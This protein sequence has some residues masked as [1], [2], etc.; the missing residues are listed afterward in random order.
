[1]DTCFRRY[2]EEKLVSGIVLC[3]IPFRRHRAAGYRASPNS[4]NFPRL[5]VHPFETFTNSSR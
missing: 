3:V 2:D 5:F 4:R 1:M